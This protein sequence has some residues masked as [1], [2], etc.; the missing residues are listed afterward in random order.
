VTLRPCAL[1]GVGP[2]ACVSVKAIHPHRAPSCIY[3]SIV[4]SMSRSIGFK[5]KTRKKTTDDQTDSKQESKRT[6]KQAEQ[7]T[8][9]IK[10]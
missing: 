5:A 6:S 3:Y 8:V 9:K 2:A 7:K 1:E 4:S 10:I